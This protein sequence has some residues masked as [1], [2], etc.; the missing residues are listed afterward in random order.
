M[1]KAIVNGQEISGEAVG[2]E[3]DRLVKFYMSHGMS[4]AEIKQ[5]LPKLEEKALEQA[6]AQGDTAKMRAAM[7]A[8]RHTIDTLETMVDADLWPVPTYAQML[9]IHSR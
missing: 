6:I 5:N 1:K 2:F 4:A 7:N 3:L 8:A 9:N